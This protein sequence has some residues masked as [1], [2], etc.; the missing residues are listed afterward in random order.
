MNGQKLFGPRRSIRMPGF[1]YGGEGAY[2]LTICAF[3]ER[4]LFGSVRNGQVKL[5]ELGTFVL[6]CWTA[7]PQHFEHAIVDAHIVMPNHLHG[8]VVLHSGERPG[9]EQSEKFQKPVAGSIPTLVRAFKAA[10][11]LRAR[12]AAIELSDPLWQRSYYE[13][14]LRSGKEFTD[15]TRYILENPGCWQSDEENP[16]RIQTGHGIEP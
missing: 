2:F 8:I 6:E 10:V 4:C 15:A 7:V 12:R 3:Q 14:V 9:K 11:T 16:Q 13:R 5:N 1:H